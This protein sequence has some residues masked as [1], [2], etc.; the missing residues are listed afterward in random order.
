MR[1]LI[2]G[3][4][5]MGPAAAFNALSDPAVT[6]VSLADADP[7]RLAAAR[8]R[9][10]PFGA[11]ARLATHA[12]D[13]D[14]QERAAALMWESDVV[15]SALPW[16][17]SVAAIEAALAADR[18][19]LDLALPPYGVI[20]P[21]RQRVEAAGG[22]IYLSCGLEPGLTEIIA[23]FLGE[24]LERVDEVHIKCGG[25]PEQPAPPLGYKIVFGGTRLPLYDT[26]AHEVVDGHWQP[27]ARYSGV[28]AVSFTGVGDCEAWHEGFVPWLLDV[29]ALRG[30]RR[31]TQKT[32]RWPGYA[33]KA[34]V[35]R[36]L[37]LL[38][39]APVSVD[40]V[41]VTPKHVVD[42][43]LAPHVR[44]NEG[45]RDITV[46]RVEALGQK[47][48]RARRYRVDM[49]DRYDATLG[50][51]SMARTTAFTGAI[52]ARMIARGDL[53]GRGLFTPEQAITGPLF[54]RL[55]AELAAAGIHFDLSVEKVKPLRTGG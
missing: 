22:A 55:L 23:R 21:L 35:L 54:D 34:G 44:L 39:L 2:I 50:F 49:V 30:L 8:R 28:E 13:V 31:G 24:K 36:D 53:G 26:D 15:I 45:E 46:F 40:G 41:S 37:G 52:I 6:N 48:G 5:L 1:I 19:L 33:A 47:K 11:D 10:G 3:S 18:P 42:A 43:V 29:P 27:V 25:I 17:A 12:L 32:V 14:D 7:A 16:Q 4:G 51:T 20:Q 9:L 38:S